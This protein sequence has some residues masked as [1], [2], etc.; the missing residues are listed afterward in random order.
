MSEQKSKAQVA[1]GKARMV[2]RGSLPSFLLIAVVFALTAGP[3]SAENGFFP[4]MDRLELG[5]FL[6][7]SGR[8]SDRERLVAANFD[9][10][11]FRPYGGEKLANSE[12]DDNYHVFKTSFTI[13]P[14]F[15]DKNLTLYISYFDMPVLIR[16]ND[17]VVYRKGLAQESGGGEVY[18]TGNQAATDVPLAAS[19]I[20]YD[21]PNTLTI[22]MFPLYEDSP[23]PELSIARYADNAAKVFF[24]NF[25]NIHL[26]VAA[27]FLAV[28]VA[29]YHFGIFVSRG[30]R[31][32]KYIF[33]SLLSMSFALAY[34]NIGFS[35]DSNYY[36]A[37]LKITRCCQLLSFGFYS[38]Y[39]IE[40]SGLS[41]R[42]E[43]II[44]GGII[45]YS[46]VCVMFV[47]FQKDKHAVSLAFDFITNIY[48][49]SLLLLC[50][51]FLLASV[52]VKKDKMVIPLLF[53]TAAVSAASLR[54][55]VLLTNAVQP[56][57]WY[58]P[59]AFLIL[60]IVIYGMLIYEEKLVYRKLDQ[61]NAILEM[62]VQ[63][64]TLEL[65]EQ[66]EIAVDA[67]RSKGE[68]FAT[69]NHELK[70]PLTVISVHVQQAAELYFAGGKGEEEKKTIINS[71][72]RA[73]EEIMNASRIIEN[74]LRV[75]AMQQGKR[76]MK[77]LQL[78]AL[79]RNSAEAYRAVL[80]R[81]GN[82][83][84]L[85]IA[86]GMGCVHGNAD[87]LIQVMVNLLS[88]ANRHTRGGTIAVEAEQDGGRIAVSVADNG[89]G[90]APDLLPHIF[91][92]GVSGVDSS[93]MG[94][95]ICEKI[96]KA[97]KGEI[98]LESGRGMGTK[99][100][101]ALPIGKGGFEK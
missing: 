16:I 95:A 94:L 36:V 85:S 37:M 99:V 60:I 18:S 7:F 76:Q 81:C 93:G 11:G 24:K 42:Q 5:G 82:R 57:F 46:I 79:L 21:A 52:I 73:Q 70:N 50:L 47:A 40:S 72:R 38:L 13:S 41:E 23:L 54:D 48:I 39:V 75:A 101:F 2:C 43:K 92:W 56:L 35:F 90:I 29:M 63:E 9:V 59:Y 97:H 66:V 17:I 80:E 96:I 53:T 45:L 74:A 77:P 44:V 100:V 91:E 15:A 65:R 64:R 67:S 68:F 1:I 34:A 89:E 58:V 33:F 84:E 22:E 25:L 26:V 28:L 69:I 4:G 62:T 31:D 83:L 8:N 12:D 27:Q 51:V 87:Q 19:M 55:I 78:D 14:E 10:P 71:L 6:V 30:S 61:S 32:K 3:A 49:I 88:N 98:R 86:D 20:N